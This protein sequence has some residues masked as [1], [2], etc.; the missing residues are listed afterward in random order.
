MTFVSVIDW[1]AIL[2]IVVLDI[3]LGVDNTIV[4]ALACAALPAVL[5]LRAL[6][7]G[8]L[9]ADVLRGVLLAAANYVMDIPYLK[10]TAG[11]Y[12]L[13]IGY[14]LLVAGNDDNPTVEQH[15]TVLASI[16]TI[17][18]FRCCRL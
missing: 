6:L 14:K 2:K 15:D 7:L 16:W 18:D 17:I 12:L 9:G 3:M 1:S 11:A 8:T 4:I 13:Y 5:R 10:I